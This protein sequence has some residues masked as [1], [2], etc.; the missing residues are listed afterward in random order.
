MGLG[1]NWEGDSDAIKNGELGGCGV[2]DLVSTF[3]QNRVAHWWEQ[4]GN[5]SYV[6]FYYFYFIFIFIFIFIF[7]E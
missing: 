2:D 7:V 3:V 4:T 5:I 1:N 6:T